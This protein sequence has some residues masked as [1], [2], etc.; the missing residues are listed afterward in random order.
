V[1]FFAIWFGTAQ[2]YGPFISSNPH[3]TDLAMQLFCGLQAAVVLIVQALQG[4]QQ[5]LRQMWHAE[6]IDS[7]HQLELR[8]QQRTQEL[9]LANQQLELLSVTDPLTQ[10]AN[11]RRF[12]DY[13]LAEWHRACR[14]Q[15]PLGLMMIDVDWFKD[16]N[17]CYGHLQGDECLRQI[18]NLLKL[19]AR[20]ATDL[21]ARFGGEE[22]TLVV[23]HADH[24]Y[25]RQQ[26]ELIRLAFASLNIPHQASPLG[27]V[28]VS[29]GVAAMIPTA[30]QM[31]ELLIERADQALY[32]AKKQGRNQVVVSLQPTES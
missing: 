15:Q 10:L 16:Y 21:A 9:E 13:L 29:I 17:D 1:T 23:P 24:L 28:T 30:E 12:D 8:V 4:E 19:G 3:D 20:R 11:R 31:P 14:L 18:G 32:Q 7:N 5:K 27:R 6:L 26:A 25:L 22:F 2:G